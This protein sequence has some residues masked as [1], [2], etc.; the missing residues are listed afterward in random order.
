MLLY[1]MEKAHAYMIF[2]LTIIAVV[3]I[4]AFTYSYR[5]VRGIQTDV[6]QIKS[7]VSSR[8]GGVVDRIKSRIPWLT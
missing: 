4:V 5:M 2:L 3:L 7:D 8:I 6:E 1:G